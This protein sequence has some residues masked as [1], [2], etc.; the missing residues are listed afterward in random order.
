MHNVYL[1]GNSDVVYLANAAN[2]MISVSALVAGADTLIPMK[3]NGD[4]GFFT[5][6]RPYVHLRGLTMANLNLHHLH[7]GNPYAVLG[8]RGNAFER[9]TVQASSDAFR[10]GVAVAMAFIER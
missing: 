7:Q 5:T 2:P 3:M 1:N 4:A 10:S 9:Y 8:L 6:T